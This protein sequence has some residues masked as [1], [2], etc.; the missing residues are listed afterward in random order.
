[1]VLDFKV[2]SDFAGA[3]PAF[4]EWLALFIRRDGRGCRCLPPSRIALPKHRRSPVAHGVPPQGRFDATIT[5]H[6]GRSFGVVR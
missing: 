4:R 6:D 3:Y 1:M 5:L 2:P